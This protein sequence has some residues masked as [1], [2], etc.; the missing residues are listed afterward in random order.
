MINNYA[1]NYTRTL[2][3]QQ[4]NKAQEH[5]KGAFLKSTFLLTPSKKIRTC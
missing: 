5:K 1:C 4:K 2:L 3:K